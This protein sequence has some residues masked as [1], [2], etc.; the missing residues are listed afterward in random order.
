V[1]PV[2]PPRFETR[3]QVP[4]G[5]LVVLG[6]GGY[7]AS[8]EQFPFY[9]KDNK[10]GAPGMSVFYVVRARVEGAGQTP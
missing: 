4:P 7:M 8:S 9:D 6:Q 5:K 1:D 10:G 3:V 2:G